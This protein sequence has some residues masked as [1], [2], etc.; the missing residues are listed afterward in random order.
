MNR[1]GPGRLIMPPLCAGPSQANPQPRS[2]V[3]GPDPYLHRMR[4]TVD[5]WDLQNTAEEN[6]QRIS[7][8]FELLAC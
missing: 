3:F 6:G 1:G 7:P 2:K 5:T 8:D 4:G